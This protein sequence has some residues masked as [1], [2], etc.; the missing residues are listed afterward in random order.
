MTRPTPAIGVREYRKQ[1]LARCRELWRSLTQRHRDLYA[2]PSIGGDDPGLELDAHLADPRL[3]RMWVAEDGARILGLCGLLLSDEESELEPIVVDPEHRSRGIGRQL[4]LRA[5]EESRRLGLK[6][7]NV[8]PV[9]RNVEAIRFFHREGF[10]LL[11]RL[12]LSMP[13]DSESS[14]WKEGVE[15]HERRFRY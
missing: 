13:L 6:Y 15:I 1:D 4:A 2:D 12:E 3:A 9:G 14:G 8:R 7:L 11:G 5:L 10:R